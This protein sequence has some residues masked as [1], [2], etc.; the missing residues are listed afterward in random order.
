M[1]M[2]GHYIGVVKYS[3]DVTCF[4]FITWLNGSLFSTIV[5]EGFWLQLFFV[6]SG[7]LLSYAKI[8]N[9]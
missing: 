5:D 4:P 7:F 1:I 9:F 6:I 8:T 3:Q 2:I